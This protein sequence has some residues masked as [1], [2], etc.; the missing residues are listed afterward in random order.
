MLLYLVGL[1]SW[2]GLVGSLFSPEY[3]YFILFYLATFAFDYVLYVFRSDLKAKPL[4][5]KLRN[6]YKMTFVVR[7]TF[8]LVYLFVS[9]QVE[10]LT[11]ALYAVTIL[12]QQV[13][14]LLVQFP[15]ERIHKL[16]LPYGVRNIKAKAGYLKFLR[17]PGTQKKK[18][19]D[20][21]LYSEVIFLSGLIVNALYSVSFIYAF[22]IG[23]TVLLGLFLY[24][25]KSFMRV[26]NRVQDGSYINSLLEQVVNKR[27]SVVVHFSGNSQSTYQLNSWVKILEQL[28]RKVLIIIR[29]R[30]HADNLIQTSIPVIYASKLLDLE[31]FVTPTMKVALYVANV[32]PNLHLLRNFR[33]KHVFLGHGDSDKVSSMNNFTRVYD[34]IYVAGEA[35]IE[36]YLAAGVDVARE[37]FDVIGRPQLGEVVVNQTPVSDKICILYAPTWEGYFKDSDYSSFLT[38][39]SDLIDFVTSKP[40]KFSLIIKPHPLTGNVDSDVKKHLEFIKSKSIMTDGVEWIDASTSTKTLFDCFNQSDMMITDVSSVL[41]DYLQSEKPLILTNPKSHTE[42]ELFEMFSVSRSAYILNNGL[43]SIND[44]I[45]IILRGDVKIDS[46]R[47]MKKY[48]LGG[49]DEPLLEMNT[50]INTLYEKAITDAGGFEVSESEDSLSVEMLNT[51]TNNGGY[52]KSG[53]VWIRSDYGYVDTG[54]FVIGDVLLVESINKVKKD[55][56]SNI[57]SGL[58]SIVEA[59]YDPKELD[60]CL[61]IRRFGSKNKLSSFLPAKS[62]NISIFDKSGA[63]KLGRGSL[64]RGLYSELLAKDIDT[65]AKILN[66]LK[67]NTGGSAIGAL[68]LHTP[69]AYL[70]PEYFSDCKKVVVHEINRTGQFNGKPT[71]N[72]ITQK[73][74]AVVSASYSEKNKGYQVILD[75]EVEKG[76]NL[77]KGNISFSTYNDHASIPNKLSGDVSCGH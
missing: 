9:L 13:F 61:K 62:L 73:E 27:A 44:L 34:R 40:H 15:L 10:E 14:F 63:L 1:L 33:L 60:F 42:E 29:E 5:K 24:S 65:N 55:Q 68:W 35:A 6:N 23:A 11:L 30:H 69:Y 17:S 28:D 59:A 2:V 12:C 76:V 8:L 54:Y 75:Y 20:S 72:L 46:R 18:I 41:S 67:T 47:S 4:I 50:A 43:N 49:V 74:Y 39:A 22:V 48:I 16:N 71:S 77:V 45:G 56:G 7:Q 25:Y 32:G 31:M 38:V 52:S 66:G 36:R 19:M 21:V 64:D 57:Q 70:A 3:T 37:A 26:S 58:Y 51:T 53:S